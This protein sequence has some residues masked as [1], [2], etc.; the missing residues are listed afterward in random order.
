VV[1]AVLLVC[2]LLPT[3][4]ATYGYATITPEEMA[5]RRAEATT[6]IEQNNHA[7]AQGTYWEATRARVAMQ[8]FIYR[9]VQSFLTGYSIFFTTVLLGF[10]AARSG[11]VHRIG[12]RK[13]FLKKAMVWCLAIGLVC[14]AA[15][16]V[17]FRYV[18]PFQI[19]PLGMFLTTMYTLGRPTLMLAYAITLVLLIDAGWWP[20]LFRSL[21]FVGR[22]PLTNY[23]L[24]S[25][26]CTLLFY[27]YGFGAIGGIKPAAAFALSLAIWG[28]QIPLSVLWFRHFRFGPME[29]LWRAATY[30]AVRAARPHA[31]AAPAIE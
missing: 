1:W 7:I 9:E 22:M 31:V 6:R 21:T 27:G 25:V 10:W 28:L 17:G 29:W 24:Q 12:E 19:S 4:I 16:A 14:G 8:Q 11:Y 5:R 30:G 23:L 3:A 18:V 26:I 20:R 13:A 15:M 2:L